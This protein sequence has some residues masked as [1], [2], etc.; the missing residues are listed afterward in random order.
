MSW[1]NLIWFGLV[2]C[3]SF[4]PF[5]IWGIWTF[6][7]GTSLCY[8]VF[9]RNN[10]VTKKSTLV[11]LCRDGWDCLT[12]GD[13]TI[14]CTFLGDYGPL[15]K[16]GVEKARIWSFRMRL[17]AIF[18]HDSREWCFQMPL[19][20]KICGYTQWMFFLLYCELQLCMIFR[21]SFN[22]FCRVPHCLKKSWRSKVHT[23]QK[24]FKCW[25]HWPAPSKSS[26]LIVRPGKR[27]TQWT[28]DMFPLPF[29]TRN[30]KRWFEMPRR[31]PCKGGKG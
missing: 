7:N 28:L 16:S 19:F 25:S 12:V 21:C 24:G 6:D 15:Y 10:W 13:S 20:F 8:L 26:K 14:Y 18:T 1:Y 22:H 30:R 27:W 11:D 2:C 5:V 17:S 31:R 9:L 3:S 23:Q 4:G 29:A